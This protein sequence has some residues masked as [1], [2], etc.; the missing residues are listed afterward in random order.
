[1]DPNSVNTNKIP[2]L[3]LEV[4]TIRTCLLVFLGNLLFNRYLFNGCSGNIE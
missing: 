1:M 2:L 4:I 3:I